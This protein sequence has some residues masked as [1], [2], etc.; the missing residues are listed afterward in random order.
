MV[1]CESVQRTVNPNAHIKG[2]LEIAEVLLND[3]E[4]LGVRKNIH[5]NVNL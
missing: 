2:F 5:K 1:F 3:F 4:E